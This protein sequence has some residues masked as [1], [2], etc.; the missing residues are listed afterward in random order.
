MQ[1]SSFLTL[2]QRVII[3]AKQG[4]IQ[5]AL[6]IIECEDPDWFVKS[7]SNLIVR[8]QEIYL[9][10]LGLFPKYSFDSF[11]IPKHL[12][13]EMFC[14]F[15]QIKITKNKSIIVIAKSDLQK[16]E[17]MRA[18]FEQKLNF[19]TFLITN[20]ADLADCDFKSHEVFLFTGM[21]FSTNSL[22]DV[23]D[24]VS[25]NDQ[26]ITIYAFDEICNPEQEEI[27]DSDEEEQMDE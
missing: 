26:K 2:S 24:L 20:W 22:S 9:I 23:D 18:Y 13:E 6:D 8:L 5:K 16:V 21:N 15:D 14:F 25:S 3:L 10:Q 4:N 27:T 12:L 19:K 17:F 1:N 7:G 11:V